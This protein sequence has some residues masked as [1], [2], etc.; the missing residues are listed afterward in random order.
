MYI[1]GMMVDIIWLDPLLHQMIIHIYM[2]HICQW[3]LSFRFPSTFP[4]SASAFVSSP[5]FAHKLLD[6]LWPFIFLCI[7]SLIM[8]ST[9]V[10]KA[11]FFSTPRDRMYKYYGWYGWRWWKMCC[12]HFLCIRTCRLWCLFMITVHTLSDR[13]MLLKYAWMVYQHCINVYDWAAC[14]MIGGKYILLMWHVLSFIC[15]S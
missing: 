6:G 9:Y 14:H 7:M 3:L 15:S 5:P 4:A 10:A 2:L 1:I 11:G 8:D 13:H 12:I